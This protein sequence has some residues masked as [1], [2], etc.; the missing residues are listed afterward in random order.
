MLQTMSPEGRAM[1]ANVL[2]LAAQCGLKTRV[3]DVSERDRDAMRALRARGIGPT[4]IGRRYNIAFF[5]AHNLTRGYAPAKKA[6][7]APSKAWCDLIAAQAPKLRPIAVRYCRNTPD[8]DD[9]VQDTIVRALQNEAAFAPGT[10]LMGWLSVMLR[11]NFL[12][13]KRSRWREVEDTDG[14]YAGRM[15]S[16]PEQGDA[17]DLSRLLEAMNRLP[18]GQGQALRLVFI[19]GL[20]YEE[21]AKQLGCPEGTV[22]SRVNRAREGLTAA[23]GITS[24][25]FASDGVLAACIVD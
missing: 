9:L 22:K 1:A 18:S 3:G 15:K 8:A 14:G 12:G 5:L 2:V 16:V 6:R 21:A 19:D 17:F 4:E 24:S 20:T 11:N 23:L 13:Q 25:D 7:K 10:N